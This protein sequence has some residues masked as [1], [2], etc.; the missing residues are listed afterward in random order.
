MTLSARD[1]RVLAELE[2]DLEAGREPRR[3]PVPT[4]LGGGWLVCVLLFVALLIGTWVPV[5]VAAV[6]TV[7]V[8]VHVAR[9]TRSRTRARS[10]QL[11]WR[12]RLA[13]RHRYNSSP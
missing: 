13:R 10:P 4:V 1:Q 6:V 12:A 3:I 5:V 8:G 11:G 7:L 2:A 9:L